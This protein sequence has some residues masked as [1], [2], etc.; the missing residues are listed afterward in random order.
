MRAPKF[1]NGAFAAI[2]CFVIVHAASAQPPAG[3]LKFEVASVRLTTS[4]PLDNGARPAPNGVEFS[5][6][7]VTINGFVLKAIIARAYAT[8]MNRVMGAD[9]T[10]QDRVIIQ[11]LMAEGATKDQLPEMLRALLAERFHLVAHA[12]ALPE[13]VFALVTAKKGLKLNL[14][15][16]LDRT[17]CTGWSE[18]HSFGAE[19]SCVSVQRTG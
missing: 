2:L 1:I 17:S 5:G 8:D 9:W 10:A 12:T 3:E 6:S 18:D 19:Q 13:P 4:L 7:R 16:D 14:P 15:H 11:A